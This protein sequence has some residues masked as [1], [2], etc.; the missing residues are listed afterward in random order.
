MKVE[1]KFFYEEEPEEEKAVNFKCGKCRYL[2]CGQNVFLYSVVASNIDMCYNLRKMEDFIMRDYSNFSDF[3]F[4]KKNAVADMEG[5]T[6]FL[7]QNFKKISDWQSW[8]KKYAGVYNHGI[9]YID[10]S[11]D[12]KKIA[13]CLA[14]ALKYLCQ[15]SKDALLQLTADISSSEYLARALKH[16]NM[17]QETVKEIIKL[18]ATK[19]PDTYD[20]LYRRLN[21]LIQ[22]HPSYK[23]IYTRERETYM[24]KNPGFWKNRAKRTKIVQDLFEFVFDANKWEI[25]EYLADNHSE[26]FTQLNKTAAIR[27]VHY[28]AQK[29]YEHYKDMDR[30]SLPK[31]LQTYIRGIERELLRKKHGKEQAKLII[32]EDKK[33]KKLSLQDENGKLKVFFTVNGKQVETY[34]EYWNLTQEFIKEGTTIPNFCRM[35]NISDTNGFDKMLKQMAA[36]NEAIKESLEKILKEHQEYYV[37]LGN[38]RIDAALGGVA[39]VSSLTSAGDSFSLSDAF[40]FIENRNSSADECVNLIENI[41]DYYE[42]RLDSYD[43]NKKTA[44]NVLKRLSYNEVNFIKGK[45]PKAT[46]NAE[47]I[48]KCLA[49]LN[50]V[51]AKSTRSPQ[52]LIDL[53][54]KIRTIGQ[55]LAEYNLQF[56]SKNTLGALS[57]IDENGVRHPVEQSHIDEAYNIAKEHTLSFSNSTMKELLRVIVLN[58]ASKKN[59]RK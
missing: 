58:E 16:N 1:L 43:P 36:N 42:D 52:D 5:Y 53:S 14:T 25:F 18:A 12:R 33:N 7:V 38:E 17:D 30:S 59:G 22:A 45:N 41:V 40:S 35:Y 8:I 3:V 51:K 9:T 23:E 39:G 26:L 10:N 11:E 57:F 48:S 32:E 2:I 46:V 6:N 54:N 44:D 34:D 19:H 29:V 37:K 13:G 56:S 47:F 50:N 15:N 21:Q 4:T 20:H 28:P 31:K 55:R 24:L 27:N 49:A